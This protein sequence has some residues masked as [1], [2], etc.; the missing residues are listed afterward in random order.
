MAPLRLPPVSGYATCNVWHPTHSLRGSHRSSMFSSSLGH[1]GWPICSY[2]FKQLP[3]PSP[4]LSLSAACKV[5]VTG[6]NC[7][8]QC[9]FFFLSHTQAYYP[10][11]SQP[12]FPFFCFFFAIRKIT[13]L[14]KF[15][16]C[17]IKQWGSAAA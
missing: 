12:E 6:C 2:K 15:A 5:F 16:A 11:Y 10:G 17:R 7:N 14:N 4:S 9:A 3:V 8:Q 1:A 13:D